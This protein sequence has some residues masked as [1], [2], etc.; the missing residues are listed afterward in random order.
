MTDLL[1]GVAHRALQPLA[2]SGGLRLGL[3]LS[4]G[5]GQGGGGG[6]PP[7]TFSVFSMNMS[8]SRYYLGVRPLTNLAWYAPWAL[9]TSSVDPPMLVPTNIT[10]DGELVLVPT[11]KVAA[12]TPQN[13]NVSGS[14]MILYWEG[15]STGVSLTG[16]GIS[17]SG[18]PV[19]ANG[20]AGWT[21]E[22]THTWSVFST[23][24]AL[25][26][27]TQSALT[28]AAPTN[29][30][31]VE[32]S[33]W[34]AAGGNPDN[35]SFW[36]ADYVAWHAGQDTEY[37]RFMD[38]MDVNLD[39]YRDIAWADRATV[40]FTHA[41]PALYAYLKWVPGGVEAEALR[42]GA[43]EYYTDTAYSGART[44]LPLD[45]FMEN[46]NS[47]AVTLNAPSGAGSAPV[48]DDT[49]TPGEMHITISPAA[50]VATAA[51]LTSYINGDASLFRWIRASGTGTTNIGAQAK[52][53]LQYG[54]EGGAPGGMPLDRM[55]ELCVLTGKKPWFT[56][57]F[58]V[59]DDYVTQFWDYADANLPGANRP[60]RHEDHNETWNPGFRIYGYIAQKAVR[61]GG[62]AT[63]ATVRGNNHIRKQDLAV[64]ACPDVIRVLGYQNYNTSDLTALQAVSGVNAATDDGAGAI[65][66]GDG[67]AGG[68]N[69]IW[70][71]PTPTTDV[72]VLTERVLSTIPELVARAVTNKNNCTSAGWTN[73]FYELNQGIYG[74]APTLADMQ[75]WQ[76]DALQR[77]IIGIGLSE[78]DRFDVATETRPLFMDAYPITNST[79]SWGFHETQLTADVDSPKWL[80]VLDAIDGLYPGYYD[81]SDTLALSD[82]VVYVGTPVS[83]VEPTKYNVS[84][85]AYLWRAD[86]GATAGTGATT[87]TYTPAGGD[88][89]KV[90][91][92][93]IT[94]T[95]TNGVD[96]QYTS[97]A[98]DAV[99]PVTKF[100]VWDNARVA[101]N[102][103]NITLPADWTD[104]HTIHLIGCGGNGA[105]GTTSVY[106]NGGGGGAAGGANIPGLT[107]AANYSATIPLGGGAAAVTFNAGAVSVDYGRNGATTINAPGAGG[108]SANNVGCN[109]YSYSGGTGGSVG[110]TFRGCGGGGGS[111]GPDGAGKN[112]GNETGGGGGGGGGSNGGSSTAGVNGAGG[113]GG[114]GGIGSTG[115]A[116]G[117]GTNGSGA[118]TAG[119]NGSGGG[120]G[121]ANTDPFQAGKNG[122]QQ[123][124]WTDTLL[125][126]TAG[127]GGGGGGAGSGGTAANAVGGNGGGYGGGGSGRSSSA[128]S[129]GLGS[130]AV[131]V[132]EWVP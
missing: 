90:L 101:A 120:A 84:A 49:T 65:Y 77:R 59:D 67:Y 70:T 111:A 132:L 100:Q 128:V 78:C 96:H 76:R 33:L 52:T 35:L 28:G 109:V 56:T 95:G 106:R 48:F 74:G 23:A 22:R 122:G 89:G 69:A 34:D 3:G 11:G 15:S 43:Q 127:P 39:W 50:G 123:I 51:Q 60:A 121:C 113:T 98:S 104:T 8:P 6:P 10:R 42:I 54:Q 58:R 80:A 94:L 73:S 85:T 26:N 62:G 83:V 16:S 87:D 13:P 105:S 25:I 63:A 110:T 12:K 131:I 79:G 29:V 112:G 4:L 31:Y 114:N 18:S 68:G 116:G 2:L 115:T 72:E 41:A 9:T 92:C 124:I 53:Y 107:P 55:I 108:L 99:L 64:A 1:S 40:P 97:P 86:G 81:L 66:L 45:P 93:E 30:Y 5:G 91:T 75:T 27:V 7:P 102:G 38:W 103:G 71:S 117:L 88:V 36:H 129:S 24:T 17:G 19:S 118:A 32:K 20:G 47:V 21:I 37:L 130:P 82:T 126:T 125:S 46:G 44:N 61:D 119:S 57:N 14:A